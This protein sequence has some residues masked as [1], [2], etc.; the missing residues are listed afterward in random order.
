MNEELISKE[1]ALRLLASAK[2][3]AEKAYKGDRHKGVLSGLNIANSLIERIET[4]EE[5]EEN[6]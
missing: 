5:A 6:G 1:Q 2:K 4:P 3:N